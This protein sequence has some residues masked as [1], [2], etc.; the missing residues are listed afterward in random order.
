M[1]YE[2]QVIKVFDGQESYAFHG[3]TMKNLS[4]FY[5]SLLSFGDWSG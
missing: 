4:S 1:S 2:H 3:D 5:K